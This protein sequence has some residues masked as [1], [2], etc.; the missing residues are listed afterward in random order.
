MG[1]LDLLLG[2]EA[3]SSSDDKYIVY[4]KMQPLLATIHFQQHPLC[5]SILSKL[6]SFLQPHAKLYQ[7]LLPTNITTLLHLTASLLATPTL[8]DCTLPTL[9]HYTQLLEEYISFGNPDTRVLL[10]VTWNIRSLSSNH[11][12]IPTEE[13]EK[14]IGRLL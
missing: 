9:E 12:I 2:L 14:L 13:K 1:G 3:C 7:H 11:N 4:S 6:L 10:Q 5:F 8:H